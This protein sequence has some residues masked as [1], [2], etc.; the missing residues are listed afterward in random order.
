MHGT[1]KYTGMLQAT[2]D[3]LR[4]EGLKVFVIFVMRVL[5]ILL[6]YSRLAF[7][8]DSIFFSIAY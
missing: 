1:S 2:K 6:R 4:E 7:E 5:E 8:A 3:I